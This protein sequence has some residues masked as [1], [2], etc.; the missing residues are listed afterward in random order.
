MVQDVLI[1]RCGR[2]KSSTDNESVHGILRAQKLKPYIPR[3]V[4]I[5]RRCWKYT[6]AEGGHFEH[7]RA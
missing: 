1:G 6:V 7:A 4:H 3:L 5:R 2:K